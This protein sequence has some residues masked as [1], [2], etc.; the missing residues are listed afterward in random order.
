MHLFDRATLKLTA[1]YTAIILTLSVAFS[2]A[3]GFT[4]AHEMTRPLR[5]SSSLQRQ[6][7]RQNDGDSLQQIFARRAR[8][9]SRRI[10][11]RLVLINVGVLALGAVASYFLARWSLQPLRRAMAKESRFVS[12]ASHELR[13]PLAVMITEN[14]VALR[15]QKAGRGEL[16][17]Q[18]ASNLDEARKLQQLADY[19]L[20]LNRAGA[21]IAKTE[22]DL[23]APIDDALARI[24]PQADAK[25][26]ALRAEIQPVTITSNAENLTEICAI[27]LENAVK[28]SPAKSVVTV[29]A[30]AQEIVIADNGVG[31]APQDLPHIFD[32]FY[33][34]EEARSTAGYGLGLSLAEKLARQIGAKITAAS[35]AGH[36]ATFTI[37]L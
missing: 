7:A 11:T 35:E 31:I 27:I 33:R 26:I 3:I 24:R 13:T 17:E 36:G 15:D 29:A 1:I 34:A 25:K 9:S 19:L 21:A 10:I 14:E 2:A 18:V 30:D 8:E 32:R 20:K 5:A 22:I 28:Y 16:R 6:I 37:K 12:D 4:A 23:A